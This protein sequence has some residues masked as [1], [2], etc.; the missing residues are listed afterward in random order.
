MRRPHDRRSRRVRRH[1]RAVPPGCSR[2]PAKCHGRA[3]STGCC[4]Q[5]DR[6]ATGST[7][8]GSAL[9]PWA[10]QAP[11]PARPA[12]RSP[13]RCQR[14]QRSFAPRAPGLELGRGAGTRAIFAGTPPFAQSDRVPRSRR[15]GAAPAHLTTWRRRLCTSGLS[16]S[17]WPHA[18][19][20]ACGAPAAAETLSRLG[21]LASGHTCSR[22]WRRQFPR[23]GSRPVFS[24]D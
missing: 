16:W 23:P 5:A 7:R 24:V 17:E 22:R 10:H 20:T 15:Q 9:T 19:R 1:A 11:A 3:E 14:S 13:L 8:Y 21:R 18:N 12:T 2:P 6:S 4:P